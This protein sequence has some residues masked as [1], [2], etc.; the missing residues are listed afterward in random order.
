[1]A[2]SSQH[3]LQKDNFE[4]DKDSKIKLKQNCKKN[5]TSADGRETDLQSFQDLFSSDKDCSTAPISTNSK[6]LFSTVVSYF[7]CLLEFRYGKFQKNF[8]TFFILL[9][10]KFFVLKKPIYLDKSRKKIFLD[11]NFQILSVNLEHGFINYYI[12]E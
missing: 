4:I 1:M 7:P 10:K 8:R 12:T 3:R 2:V 5:T 6:S 11:G 9:A